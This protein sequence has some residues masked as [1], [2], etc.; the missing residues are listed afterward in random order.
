[1]HAPLIILDCQDGN[2]INTEPRYKESEDGAHGIHS[3]RLFDL[4]LHANL[5]GILCGLNRRQ[6]QDRDN[7]LRF[8]IRPGI[9]LLQ[10]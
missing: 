2:C 8:A 4:I 3:P 7:L 9:A 6:F 5:N 10:L 1:M